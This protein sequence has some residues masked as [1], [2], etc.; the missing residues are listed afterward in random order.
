MLLW[1]DIW[2]HISFYNCH[3]WRVQSYIINLLPNILLKP[4]VQNWWIR[5]AAIDIYNTVH[6]DQYIYI[7]VLWMCI[8]VCVLFNTQICTYFILYNFI[9]YLVKERQCHKP[10]EGFQNWLDI[11]RNLSLDMRFDLN[12]DDSSSTLEKLKDQVMVLN[13]EMN[14]LSHSSNLNKRCMQIGKLFMQKFLH[15]K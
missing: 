3:L 12:A 6:F 7:K 11:K 5:W 2:Y 1:N 13:Q 14:W 4:Q 9:F 8:C 10:F 15:Q